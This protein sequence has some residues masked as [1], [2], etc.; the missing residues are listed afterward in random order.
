MKK[1]ELEIVA[2]QSSVTHMNSYAVILGEVNGTKRLP[3][4]I[5]GFE[6]QAIAVAL[7][8]LQPKRPLTHDLFTIMLSVFNVQLKEVLIYK[9]ED[10]I[11]YAQLVCSN[12]DGIINIDCRTS[13]AI[14]LAIRVECKIYSYD[15]II[16]VAGVIMEN[17]ERGTPETQT[18]PIGSGDSEPGEGLTDDSKT[19]TSMT[20]E[21]L[22]EKLEEALAGEE[23][24][25]AIAIRD[26]IK[27]RKE[28]EQ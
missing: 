4:V 2:L 19:L 10:G 6:A 14:A 16:D 11:F 7:E 23:Y 24:E 17:L 8:N 13:D 22:E 9:L 1:I 27:H 15:N 12:A 3:I 26:E 28:R 25:R 20:M 18:T 21:E 5:G